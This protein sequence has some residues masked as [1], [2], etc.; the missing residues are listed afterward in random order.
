M[1]KEVIPKKKRSSPPRGVKGKAYVRFT[2]KMLYISGPAMRMLG[3]PESIGISVDGPGRAM[4]LRPG[5]PFKLSR[6]CETEDARRIETNK[7][8]ESLL[9]YGFPRGMLGLWLT[10]LQTT[11]DGALAVSLLPDWE[12]KD[13]VHQAQQGD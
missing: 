2:P 7:A 11:M 3:M 12:A 5:G 8:L 10:Q 1:Y 13:G 6:V 4:V 9:E